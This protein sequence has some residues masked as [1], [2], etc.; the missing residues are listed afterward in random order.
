MHQFYVAYPH[1]VKDK[2][3]IQQRS[4]LH[5]LLNVL[6]L[7]KEE[8]LNIFDS[9]AN[10]YICKIKDL[11][12]NGITLEIRKKSKAKNLPIYLVVACAIPKAKIMDSIVDKLTQ[13]GVSKIIPLVTQRT[14]VKWNQDKQDRNLERW[15]R[16]SINSCQ[17]SKRISLPIIE[18][19]MNF[20]DIFKLN[21]DFSLKLIFTVSEEAES[22]KNILEK[23]PA[24]KIIILIGPEGDF[25]SQEINLAK[26]YG[27][28]PA[29]LG[30]LIL[31]V[32]TAVVSA[33]SFI[34]LY[35]EF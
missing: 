11:S 5:H 23:N 12:L 1:I 35:A 13:L 24:K 34:K 33:V 19:V 17:Q 32:E 27:F 28:I 2:I 10:L 6:R 30:T 3:I 9:E 18:R 29:S 26:T 25:S 31:R 4:L 20:E 7:K 14:V 8:T 21:E 22:L 16:I 15:R